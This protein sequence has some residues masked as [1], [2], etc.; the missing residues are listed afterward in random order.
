MFRLRIF[1]SLL[2]VIFCAAWAASAQEIQRPY[3][4]VNDFA[5]IISIEDKEKL[6]ALI[7][8]LEQKTSAEIAVVT[9]DSI[10]PYDEKEYAN[11]LFDMWKVGKRGQDNGL[12]VLLAVKE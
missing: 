1:K 12:I 5:G 10:A 6:T 9:Q 4:W 3:G 11:K 2:V 8:D 7:A